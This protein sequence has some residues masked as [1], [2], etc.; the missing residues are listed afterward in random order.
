MSDRDRSGDDPRE[1]LGELWGLLDA[2]PRGRAS[3][4]LAATTVEMAATRIPPDARRTAG[5]WAGPAVVVAGALTVGLLVGFAT[6]PNPDAAVLAD[7]PVIEHLDLLAEAGS[8]EFLAALAARMEEGQGPAA[9]RLQRFRDPTLLRAEAL[10]FEARLA[11]LRGTLADGRAADGTLVERR[12]RIAG[13]SD[14]DRTR[15][16]KSV[17]TFANLT[18]V[19]RRS[20]RELAAALVDPRQTRLQ[21]AARAWHLFVA[22]MPAPL[23][24]GY[25]S[26]TTAARLEMLERPGPERPFERRGGPLRDGVR[27]ERGPGPRGEPGPIPPGGRAEANRGEPPRPFRERGPLRT[28]GP[29][30]GAPPA[31]PAETPA[32]PR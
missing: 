32:P 26:M 9:R 2:L 5:R 6:A 8:V 13:L 23:R 27:P 3:S 24:P 25:A 16:E 21:D 30:R 22:A 14:R 1:E 17:E 11:A 12:E 18:A 4:T 28:D 31:A 29:P 7:L 19:D 15:I 20:Y 10:D